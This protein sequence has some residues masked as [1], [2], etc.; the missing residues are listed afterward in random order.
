MSEMSSQITMQPHGC[1][2]N[3]LFR[4]RPKKTSKL[5]VTGLC[6]DRWIPRTKTSNAENVSIWWRH[7][8]IADTY[9]RGCPR[10]LFLWLSKRF[11]VK[12]LTPYDTYMLRW[13][14]S[15]CTNYGI[16]DITKCTKCK[17]RRF[18]THCA[19][20]EV[21]IILKGWFSNSCCGLNFCALSV[22]L[23]SCVCHGTPLAIRLYFFR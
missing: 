10:R 11:P 22:K 3:R 8:E 12:T 2:L 5:R 16:H 20:G 4:R 19:T 15:N 23:L 17:S 21:A 18:L 9:R 13:I 14:V 7:H 1:L 6:E